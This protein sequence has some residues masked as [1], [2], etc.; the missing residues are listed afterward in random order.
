MVKKIIGTLYF[1][2]ILAVVAWAASVELD[3][4]SD[5]ILDS[6]YKVADANVSGVI[7]I[8]HGGTNSSTALNND[9][10]VVSSGGAIAESSTVSA[11]ELALLNGET[12]LANQAELNAVAALVDTDDEII[13]IINASPSTQLKHEAGGLEDD[14]SAYDGFVKITGGTTSAVSEDTIVGA[15]TAGALPAESVLPA[16]LDQDGAFTSLTG[17]WATTG[18]L[19][20]SI[21]LETDA[22][23]YT[24]S[25]AMLYGGLL[26]ESGNQQTVLLGPVA[27]GM[28]FC[29][30]ADG[31]DASA[32]IYLDCDASDHFEYDGTTMADG[33]Y[34]YNDSDLKGDRMC[35]VGINAATWLVTYG[36]DTT[37]AE[38][39]P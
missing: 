10:V 22:D 8:T 19:T 18:A 5:D 6:T 13:A 15:I 37:V 26:I 9:F 31:A 17:A 24:V 32:E 14:V 33:E 36:G 38:E 12:D 30:V 21:K 1:V 29:T 3:A 39:S 7:G 23:G 27:I 4:N 34:I 35:V 2:L 28:S 20:G 11:I 25:G 16:D